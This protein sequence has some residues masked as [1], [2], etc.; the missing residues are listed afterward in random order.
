[1]SFVTSDY[2]KRK[3]RTE[4]DVQI[5]KFLEAF[6]THI[7]GFDDSLGL[8]V[9]D[10]HPPL[11][12]VLGLPRTATTL[13]TQLIAGNLDMGCITNIA[14]RLW[15]APMAGILL[16]KAILGESIT[17]SYNSTYGTTASPGEPHEF[18]FF[19]HNLFKMHDMPPYDA[20]KIAQTIDWNSVAKSLKQI[21][22]AWEKPTVLKGFD[23]V[24]H[25]KKIYEIVPRSLFVFIERDLNEVAVSLAKGRLDYYGDINHW[26]SMYPPEYLEL[27]DKPWHQQIAGQVAGLWE[28]HEEQMAQI[29]SERL[30]RIDY[31]DLCN[32][33]KTLVT[34]VQD[35]LQNLFAV[36][37]EDTNTPPSSFEYCTESIAGE[38]KDIL[39][40]S[41]D[42]RLAR[43]PFASSVK[44]Q[45][46]P[47]D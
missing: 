42:A 21:S 43:S 32:T 26:L 17:T 31:R 1:M 24:Y 41:L 46:Q 13:C 8:P 11:V 2:S 47:K 28:L 4:F 14:A 44:K 39:L 45:S 30:I 7:T 6:N 20:K 38:Q 10:D 18:S 33:P 15:R 22:L 9:D 35:R 29:S 27:K 23:V 16:S 12:F 3:N 34:S 5:S 19:W 25:L 36:R 40:R 37:V